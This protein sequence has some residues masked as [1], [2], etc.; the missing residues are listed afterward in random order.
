MKYNNLIGSLEAR[1]REKRK[2]KAKKLKEFN[3]LKARENNLREKAGVER[4]RRD[5]EA[6][7]RDEAISAQCEK[8]IIEE[9]RKIA[10]HRGALAVYALEKKSRESEYCRNVT[11]QKMRE[12]SRKRPMYKE[13]KENRH[14]SS[15]LSPRE[16]LVQKPMRFTS[17]PPREDFKDPHIT[18]KKKSITRKAKTPCIP[19]QNRISTRLKTSSHKKYIPDIVI[20]DTKRNAEV[21]VRSSEEEENNCSPTIENETSTSKSWTIPF[22]MKV[23]KKSTNRPK[24]RSI[25]NDRKKAL[26]DTTNTTANPGTVDKGTEEDEDLSIEIRKLEHLLQKIKQSKSRTE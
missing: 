19:V 3:E 6:I 4:L 17:N 20:Y 25:R 2:L 10:D 18:T 1:L 7:Q 24:L 9:N 15:S 5:A 13:R 14:V 22:G 16:K 23:N 11:Q 12:K 21:P 8:Y 26:T